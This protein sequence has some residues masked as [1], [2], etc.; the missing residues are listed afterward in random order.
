MMLP[1]TRA[2]DFPWPAVDIDGIPCV[3]IALGKREG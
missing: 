1:R 2:W 3:S